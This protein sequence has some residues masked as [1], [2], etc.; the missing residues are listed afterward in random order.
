MI[1]KMKRFSF[2]QTRTRLRGDHAQTKV[3][4]SGG[5]D[6]QRRSAHSISNRGRRRAG[7]LSGLADDGGLAPQRISAPVC[8]QGSAGALVRFVIPQQIWP[9]RQDSNRILDLRR[10]VLIQLNYVVM[11]H[12][13]QQPAAG[14][15][16]S[17]AR[18]P[19]TDS[20]ARS[21]AESSAGIDAGPPSGRAAS[22][23]TACAAA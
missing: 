7:S 8:F 22:V 1:R 23:R 18:H 14:V 11:V 10:V 3:A 15:V 5:P 9:P 6:P 20:R 13:R 2:A 4:D 16:T 17:P 21:R 12:R 19:S